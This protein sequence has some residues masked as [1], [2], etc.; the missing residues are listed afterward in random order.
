MTR[1]RQ[2]IIYY[3]TKYNIIRIIH[4]TAALLGTHRYYSR[5]PACTLNAVGLL[6]VSGCR[7]VEMRGSP[8]LGLAPPLCVC[9]EIYLTLPYMPPPPPV[10]SV[11]SRTTQGPYDTRV[12]MQSR[13]VWGSQ[14]AS[15]AAM[16]ACSS[17]HRRG[18]RARVGRCD[19][20]PTE[21]AAGGD[22]DRAAGGRSSV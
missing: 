21:C 15:G 10:P 16:R 8:P 5:S 18:R 20:S 9:G 2:H 14:R 22:T 3:N 11:P 1:V 7:G 12:R 6:P 17:V 13:V 19:T 4:N